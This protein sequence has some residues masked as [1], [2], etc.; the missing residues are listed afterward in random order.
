MGMAGKDRTG[1]AAARTATIAARLDRLPFARFHIRLFVLGGLGYVF[2]ALDSAIVAFALP[3]LKLAWGLDIR[4]MGLIAGAA[5]IGGFFGALIAGRLGDRVGRR[6]VMM[7]A[8][9]L[10]CVAT[11]ASA[12]STNVWQFFA[13]RLIAG[14][15]ISAESVI[16]TPFLS[17]LVPGRF[18]GRFT[19]ALAGCFSLGFVLAALLGAAVIPLA[20]DAWRWA[21]VITALPIVMLLWWRRALPESPRWLEGQGRSDEAEAVVARIEALVERQH[22]ALPEPAIDLAPAAAAPAGGPKL[23][24]YAE[25]WGKALRRR[26]AVAWTIWFTIGFSYYAFFTWLPSLLVASGMSMAKGFGFSLAIYAAQIPGY[27]SAAWLN[28]VIGR[29]AVI[30][31]YMLAA[32]VAAL[33]FAFASADWQLMLGG[34]LLSLC[35]NGVYAGLYAYTPEIFPTH[36]RATGQGSSTAVSRIGAALAPLAVGLLFPLYGFV[37]VFGLTTCLLVGGALCA[38]TLGLSTRGRSLEAITAPPLA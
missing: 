32:A 9:A 34:I 11:L 20:P 12:F 17:E 25:L 5:A 22:G 26:T 28:D 24:A 3:A 14:V 21:L 13:W 38:A 2:D 8:L 4:Q 19:G 10:Y 35:M 37:G 36:V 18:R 23:R 16:I 29:R 30:A 1:D 33:G 7:S 6:K 27:F 31:S 15:G